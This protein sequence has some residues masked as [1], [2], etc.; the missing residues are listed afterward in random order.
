MNLFGNRIL[1][2][3]GFSDSGGTV[4]IFIIKATAAIL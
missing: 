2:S 4:N 3:A 1:D